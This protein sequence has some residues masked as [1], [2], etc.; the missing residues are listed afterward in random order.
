MLEVFAHWFAC[1]IVSLKHP[2]LSSG[3]DGSGPAAASAH[4]ESPVNNYCN[5]VLNDD[6]PSLRHSSMP[7]TSTR[8][9]LK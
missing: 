6:I 2:T 5:G 4:K 7:S 8:Y 3:V 9:K 1:V